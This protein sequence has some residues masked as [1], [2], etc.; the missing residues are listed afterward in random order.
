MTRSRPPDL[1]LDARV[2]AAFAS[3]LD[4]GSDANGYGVGV[5]GVEEVRNTPVMRTGVRRHQG[6]AA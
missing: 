2:G 4:E 5:D 6:T 3:L 1:V